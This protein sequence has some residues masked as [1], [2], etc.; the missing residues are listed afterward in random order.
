M[1]KRNTVIGTPFWMAPEVIQEVGYDCLADIW[2]LGITVVEMAEGRPPYADVHPMRVGSWGYNLQNVAYLT[3]LY[4]WMITC[5]QAIFMIPTK[6]PP[7]LKEPEKFSN[8]FSDFISRCLVKSPEERPSATA[9]LQ[10]FFIRSARSV[11]VLKDLVQYTLKLV[12]EEEEEESDV[13]SN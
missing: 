13:S 11:T 3:F 6:P 2:S 5:P 12:E 1:A 7:T 10:H 9:L 4:F 8:E